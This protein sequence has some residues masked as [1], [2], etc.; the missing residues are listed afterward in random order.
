[1]DALS[2]KHELIM[3]QFDV[4]RKFF[5]QTVESTP[6]EIVDTQPEHFNNTIRWH[7][8]HVLT[9]TETILGYPDISKSQLPEGYGELFE[10]GTKPGD[11]TREVP[12]VEEL[13]RHLKD[14]ANR[15]QQ[16]PVNRLNV[17]LEEPL[18]FP[19]EGVQTFE[20]L[21]GLLCMHEGIHMGQISAMKRII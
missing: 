9:S 1:M 4:T 6:E 16:I 15:I 13:T 21:A 19:F 11:W 17:T 2:S 10:M 3:N 7:I 8:G 12:S 20:D 18:S 5:I 14:Q